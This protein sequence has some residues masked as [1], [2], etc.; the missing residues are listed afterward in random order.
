MQTRNRLLEQKQHL[1]DAQ[2]QVFQSE[3]ARTRKSVWV[4]YLF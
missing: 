3:I 4:A 1:T 2:W